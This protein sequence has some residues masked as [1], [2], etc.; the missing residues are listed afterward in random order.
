[1]T[2][3]ATP[4]STTQP[5]RPRS[6]DLPWADNP[7]PWASLAITAMW[8]AVLFTSLFGG[9]FVTSS[10]GGA[11]TTTTIP[12]GV[13]LALFALFGTIAVARRGFAVPADSGTS[14][15][16]DVERRAREQLADQ[17]AA[18]EARLSTSPGQ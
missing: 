4:M 12:A 15:A 13:I 14:A 9:D 10:A 17:V 3:S 18:L 5:A 1:M 2:V 11:T 6:R 16:L 7:A 8:L